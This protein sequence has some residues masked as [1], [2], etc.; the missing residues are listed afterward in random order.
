M[1]EINAVI[2]EAANREKAFFS[3]SPD[4]PNDRPAEPIKEQEEMKNE[5]AI[6][7]IEAGRWQHDL[8]EALENT[9]PAYVYRVADE[10]CRLFDLGEEYDPYAGSGLPDFIVCNQKPSDAELR[11]ELKELA[12][13]LEE[14]EEEE[15][16]KADK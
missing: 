15:K 8:I 12:A 9:R 2:K 1:N 4:R 5:A 7:L 6:Q 11:A 16:E 14:A 3:G 10:L 13:D